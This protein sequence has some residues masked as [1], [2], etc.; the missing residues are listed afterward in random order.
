M[1]IHVEMGKCIVEWR[2]ALGFTQERLALECEISASYLR[3]IEHGQANPTI[4]ELMKIAEV[5][6]IELMNPIPMVPIAVGAAS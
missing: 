4:G 6:G 1:T 3:L 2:K 5:L